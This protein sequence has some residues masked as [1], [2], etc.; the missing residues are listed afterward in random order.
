MHLCM[1]SFLVV[2]DNRVLHELFSHVCTGRIND[3]ITS[4]KL[5]PIIA[6]HTPPCNRIVGQIVNAPGKLFDEQNVVHHFAIKTAH[7][8]GRMNQ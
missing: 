7:D 2:S 5:D 6:E 8:N 1:W 3:I 4:Y